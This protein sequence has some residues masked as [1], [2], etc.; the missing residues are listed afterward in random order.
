MNARYY[1][2]ETGRFISQDPAYLLIGDQRFKDKYQR[3][4]EMHLSDPQSLNSYSYVNNNPLRWTDPDGEILPLLGLAE[5]GMAAAGAFLMYA[6]QI[7]SF[8]QSLVT[9]LGQ[10]AT[11]DVLDNARQG[12]YGMVMFGAATAGGV[13]T[14]KISNAAL[15]IYKQTNAAGRV[16]MEGV[17]H[18]N[19]LTLIR[20][21]YK[22][23]AKVGSG[24]T[25]D[26]VRYE[27]EKVGERVGGKLH[28]IKANE[29][30]SR[31]NNIFKKYGSELNT[32]EKNVLN[33]ISSDLK[34]A[35]NIKK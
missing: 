14:G 26:A 21:N 19:V 7:T 3:T 5:L 8:A 31:I 29:M 32:Q 2:G 34:D 22:A 27:L 24:S 23:G 4:L 28:S 15:Q 10:V 20:D 13:P 30:I 35:L 1:S 17:K 12:N 11:V 33:T 16:L 25:A 9:P 6:P 18:R